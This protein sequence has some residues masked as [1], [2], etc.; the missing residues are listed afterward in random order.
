MQRQGLYRS[1]T[2]RVFGGVAGG[3]AHA[4]NIDPVIVRLI[5]AVMVIIGGGGLLLYVILWI[6][7]PEEPYEFYHGNAAPGEAGATEGET[8]PGAPYTP[9]PVYPPHR[10]SGALVV[11]I[12]FI[13]VGLVFLADRFMPY[14]RFHFRD[15]WPVVLV[16]AGLALILTSFNAIKKP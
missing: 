13:G 14:L 16:V 4:L 8:Q 1:R 7:I 2:D 6:A 12:I 11:G 5:F 10:N 15:F 3:I 9:P